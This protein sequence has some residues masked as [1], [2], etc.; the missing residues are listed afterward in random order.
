MS[1][2]KIL[3]LDDEP[4]V[5]KALTRVLRREYEL[6]SFTDGNEAL[7]ELENNLYSVLVTDMRMPE[8]NGA[9][10]LKKAHEIS[11]M[12]QKILLT[13][14]AD[15]KDASDAI[16]TGHVDFY[17]NKPWDNNDLIDKIKQ[18]VENFV[19][20]Y[21]Q[22]LINKQI[23]SRNEQLME[24]Q[25]ELMQQ[26]KDNEKALGKIET[27][28]ASFSTK[29]KQYYQTTSDILTHCIQMHSQDAFAHGE[30][31]ASQVEYLCQ[32]Y[33]FSPFYTFQTVNAAR[34]YELGKM[35]YSQADLEH[36]DI[37]LE[38]D[39]TRKKAGFVEISSSLLRKFQDFSGV[40]AIIRHIFE[41][42]DG[43][44]TP[45]GLKG[46]KVPLPCQMIQICAAFDKLVTGKTTGIPVLPTT[47]LS[48]IRDEKAGLINVKIINAFV[49]MIKAMP[50]TAANPIQ[51]AIAP[52]Q[53]RK[54]MTLAHDLPLEAAKSNYLNKGHVLSNENVKS[55]QNIA[56]NRKTPLILFIYPEVQATE[57]GN[58]EVAATESENSQS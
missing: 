39:V 45:A 54:G 37:A 51:Y 3:L 50:S 14:Y 18:C 40:A 56:E 21:Q 26:L 4:E 46:D 29:L 22:G 25:S 2:Y 36:F 33:Q 28:K 44:G 34:L 38:E 30:R 55:L 17:L 16:N 58:N 13:G 52:R 8:I 41:Y 20:E 19:N 9:T 7:K 35:Q 43:T 49:D 57:P 53:L 27:V 31:V 11:P 6:I 42:T 5:L 10:F 1:K 32:Q 47:A 15:P 23:I 12:S 48:M 24:S